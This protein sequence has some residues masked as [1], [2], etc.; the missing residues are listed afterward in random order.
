MNI[1]TNG[2]VYQI[3]ILLSYFYRN[4]FLKI[5]LLFFIFIKLELSTG[6]KSRVLS[7]FFLVKLQKFIK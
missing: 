5:F 1:Y 7:L 4:L 6:I 3:Y 2:Y